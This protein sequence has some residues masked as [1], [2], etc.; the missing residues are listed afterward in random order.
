MGASHADWSG[1]NNPREV[2]MSDFFRYNQSD[3][4]WTSTHQKPAEIMIIACD[5]IIF[6]KYKTVSD[7]GIGRKAAVNLNAHLKQQD[8]HSFTSGI[9]EL[10]YECCYPVETDDGP[11][12]NSLDPRYTVTAHK[13]ISINTHWAAS[14]GL[15]LIINW[16]SAPTRN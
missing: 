8:S 6:A 4:K 16:P 13:L 2:K 5:R 14:S 12:E 7:L 11:L 3:C 10:Y 15:A 9:R 1:T